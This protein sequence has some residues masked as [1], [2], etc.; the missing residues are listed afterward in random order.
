V[1]RRQTR[2]TLCAGSADVL[3]VSRTGGYTHLLN[4]IRARSSV[5]G[6]VSSGTEKN[7][8][9]LKKYLQ[10]SEI[11][12]QSK[13]RK[14]RRLLQVSVIRTEACEIPRNPLRRRIHACQMRRRIH[15]CHKGRKKPSH[16]VSNRKCLAVFGVSADQ[17]SQ[18]YP[19]QNML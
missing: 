16:T 12:A 1:L 8:V 14:K 3:C 7:R 11:K 10:V 17:I 6:I 2:E 5:G 18:L 4:L 13:A 9:P 19:M 15:A